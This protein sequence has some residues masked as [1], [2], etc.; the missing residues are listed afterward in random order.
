MTVVSSAGTYTPATGYTNDV[1]FDDGTV[2][3]AI[4]HKVQSTA[5]ATSPA[6]TWTNATNWGITHWFMQNLGGTK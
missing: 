2:G 4:D 3:C 1:H 6:S 5:A